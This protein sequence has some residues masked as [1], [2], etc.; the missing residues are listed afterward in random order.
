MTWDDI[1]DTLFDGTADEM[2]AV[3]CPECGGDIR[4]VYDVLDRVCFDV[5][6]ASCGSGS[7]GILG[8]S[9]DDPPNCVR[10]F[11]PEAVLNK[12]AELLQTA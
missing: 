7:H 5:V 1:E 10:F 11:G 8:T 6:C 2:L 12:N 3:S 4:Y 9:T